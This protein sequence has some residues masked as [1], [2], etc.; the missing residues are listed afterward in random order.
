MQ[1]FF[2]N[3]VTNVTSHSASLPTNSSFISNN[4]IHRCCYG[5]I[6]HTAFK[7]HSSHISALA[8][9]L[10]FQPRRFTDLRN[11]CQRLA[12]EDSTFNERKLKTVQTS[13]CSGV[14]RCSRIHSH[15]TA[16]TQ[17]L[18]RHTHESTSQTRPRRVYGSQ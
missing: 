15:Q 5:V 18:Q 2:L 3:F 11:S 6:K 1:L 14:Q 9:L 13:G 17:R 8:L 7:K 4:T 16:E 12:P 10:Y